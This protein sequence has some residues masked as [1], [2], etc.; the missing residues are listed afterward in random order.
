MSD[1]EKK[2]PIPLTDE[3]ESELMYTL[4]DGY[5]IFLMNCDILRGYPDGVLSSVMN[6]P[7]AWLYSFRNLDS[8]TEDER[9]FLFG[10][11]L[12]LPVC[13]FIS[14]LFYTEEFGIKDI[15]EIL[16]ELYENPEQHLELIREKLQ[17]ESE[18]SLTFHDVIEA[19]LE[20]EYFEK[21]WKEWMSP[22]DGEWMNKVQHQMS[23]KDATIA[24]N[25]FKTV[26]VRR[27]GF[28][29]STNKKG[30][31]VAPSAAIVDRLIEPIWNDHICE[32]FFTPNLIKECPKTTALLVE[33]I[34]KGDEDSA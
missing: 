8:I 24:K 23:K 27:S 28:F 5:E 19:A 13:G 2:E 11:S 29:G 6:I 25:I 17:D 12:S 26:Y 30:G 34:E 3:G 33:F 14:H 32:T 18:E 10:T 22:Y 20:E 16:P 31:F 7:N 15:E 21:L 9:N 1:D 4:A